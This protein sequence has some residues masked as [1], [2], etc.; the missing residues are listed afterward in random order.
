VRCAGEAGCY[1]TLGFRIAW[2]SLKPREP[3]KQI[4]NQL[5]FLRGHSILP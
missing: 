3:V 4:V 5:T 1:C 2:R